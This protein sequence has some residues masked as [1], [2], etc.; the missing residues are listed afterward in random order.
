MF[1]FGDLINGIGV[2]L[3][4]YVEIF[5]KIMGVIFGVAG[6]HLIGVL[7]FFPIIGAVIWCTFHIFVIIGN[8][9]YFISHLF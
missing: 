1:T 9:M 5:L 3:G 4:T 2:I 7:L 6:L 8:V